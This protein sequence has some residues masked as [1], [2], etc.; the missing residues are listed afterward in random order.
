MSEN[1]DTIEFKMLDYKLV[2]SDMVSFRLEDG[3]IVRIKVDLGRVGVAENF[4]NPDGTPHYNIGAGLKVEVI[5]PGGKFKVP[6]SKIKLPPSPQ[7]T[8][9]RKYG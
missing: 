7:S 2:G 6:K 1:K 9:E 8:D 4:N 5:P 3:A